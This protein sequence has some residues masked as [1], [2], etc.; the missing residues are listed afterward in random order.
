MLVVFPSS[1]VPT[2]TPVTD[3]T[4]LEGRITKETLSFK[5]QALGSLKENL[6]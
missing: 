4:I 3:L 2:E 5:N 1:T 6:I